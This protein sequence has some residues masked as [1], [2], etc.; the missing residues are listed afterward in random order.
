[1]PRIPQV[2]LLIDTSTDYSTRVIRGIDQY[3]RAHRK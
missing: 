1:M 3:V 2:A